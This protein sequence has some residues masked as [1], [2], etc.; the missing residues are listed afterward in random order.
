MDEI[1]SIPASQDAAPRG[2]CLWAGFQRPLR[3]SPAS[4]PPALHSEV[5]ADI[6][7]CD[8]LDAVGKGT[9]GL[10]RVIWCRHRQKPH[11]ENVY[12]C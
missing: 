8:I 10:L 9:E 4:A 6:S 1:F 5:P 12:F 2:Q 7:H 3:P 11:P